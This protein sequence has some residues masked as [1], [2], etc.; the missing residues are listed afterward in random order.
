[1]TYIDLINRF[2]EAYRVKKFSDIDTVIYF[3]LLNECNIRR[4]LNPFELQTRN[5]DLP[6]NCAC[7]SF[8]IVAAVTSSPSILYLTLIEFSSGSI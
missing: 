6:I 2:W 8:S 7:L 4:W 1:M 3:F 5:I